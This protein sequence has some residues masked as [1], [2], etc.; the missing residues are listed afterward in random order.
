M[1]A[2][3]F[4]LAGFQLVLP[5]DRLAT[6]Y[7]VDLS[8]SVGTVGREDALAF[9]R[10]SLAVMPEGDAAGVV[11]F[12]KDA[13]VERLPEELRQIERIRSTPVT[14]ATDIGGALRLASAL[15]PDEMQKRIVL[16]S[17]G[18][19]TTGH[20]QQEAALAAARGI[21]VETRVVGLEARDEV[22]VERIQAPSTARIGETIEV[23]GSV[24]SSVAQPAVVRLY[25]DGQLVA[26]QAPRP[27][28]RLE[29]ARLR[30][31]AVRARVPHVPD[32]RRGRP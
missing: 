20:G 27:R 21:Q 9:L 1:T 31:Q 16:I 32:G 24:A 14:A 19:D 13:L 6:V 11:A 8:D 23:V 15:F 26:T 30:G 25:T 4:A 18:N 12:G 10:E 29:S 3:V 5:V 2:L 7:V 17:D 22:L 28:G